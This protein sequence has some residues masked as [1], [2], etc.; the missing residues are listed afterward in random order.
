MGRGG[1]VQGRILRPGYLL[2]GGSSPPA[3]PGFFRLPGCRWLPPPAPGA[4]QEVLHHPSLVCPDH[5][6]SP[7]NLFS[8]PHWND[9][10][11]SAQDPTVHMEWQ[12]FNVDQHPILFKKKE[13]T[14]TTSTISKIMKHTPPRPR[15]KTEQTGPGVFLPQY[16][17]V[18]H[19]SRPCPH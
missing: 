6:N 7:L 18:Y 16:C 14:H 8:L 15:V 12:L 11:F 13:S 4:P 5:L 1:S 17:P 10:L 19:E 9:Y 3:P 2:R